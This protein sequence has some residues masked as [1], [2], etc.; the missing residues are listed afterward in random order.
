MSKDNIALDRAPA[1]GAPQL[2]AD[3]DLDCKGL[4]CP[5]P[6]Y[7]A[8]QAMAS[9]AVGKV[10]RIQCTDPGSLKDFEAFARQRGYTLLSAQN[11]NGVQTFYIR[12]ENTR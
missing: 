11:S 9:L 5:L 2:A 1:A 6:V 8:S 7:K 4:L 10:I 3:A 12:K